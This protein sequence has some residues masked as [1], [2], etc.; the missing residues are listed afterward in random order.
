GAFTSIGTAG[1]VPDAINAWWAFSSGALSSEVITATGGGGLTRFVLDVSA[2]KDTNQTSL[3]GALDAGGFQGGSYPASMTTVNATTF[4]IAAVELIF[5]SSTT[6]GAGFTLL[7]GASQMGTEY[8]VLSAAGSITG[9]FGVGFGGTS[10]IFA[11]VQATAG[12]S[13]P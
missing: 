3:T 11:I 6:A 8:Q 1:S 13:D 5:G 9:N 12:G 10:A 7:N 4:V 2:V